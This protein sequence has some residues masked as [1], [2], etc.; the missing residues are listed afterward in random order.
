MKYLIGLF[1][2]PSFA[3][4]QAPE[5][6]PA[7]HAQMQAPSFDQFKSGMQPVIDQSLPAMHQT[8]DCVSKSN[9]VEETE[10]CMKIMT[11]MAEALRQK[12]GSHVIPAPKEAS[13]GS[14]CQ[15]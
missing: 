3:F 8:R 13:A 11:D 9:S 12:T 4:A 5:G 14:D 10:K 7:P 6:Q 1:L 15:N 2:L